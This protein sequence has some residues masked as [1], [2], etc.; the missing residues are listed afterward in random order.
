MSVFIAWF[1]A[2]N[3]APPPT[4]ESIWKF[5]FAGSTKGSAVRVIAS[6]STLPVEV[7]P[8]ELL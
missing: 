8:D 3:V 4:L 5:P 1:S 2:L 7:L 6:D